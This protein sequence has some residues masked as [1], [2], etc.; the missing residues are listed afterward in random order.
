M[1]LTSRVRAFFRLGYKDQVRLAGA[2]F[3]LFL[4]RVL[5]A[6]LPFTLVRR[7]L[8]ENHAVSDPLPPVDLDPVQHARAVH[9]GRIV[10]VAAAYAPFRS[11]C[12]PQALTA[13]V[14]L[15]VCR[16]P[17]LVSFG[18]R[19][20]GDRLLAHAWVHAGGVPVTGGSGEA[21]AQVGTFTWSPGR[22]RTR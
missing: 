21:Y 16:I 19:R 3:L 1:G 9:I 13:R 8:G 18:V 5:I 17:H 20:D 22:R 2:W 11:D 12:Y 14:L 10:Q 15:A 4:S 7:L 6:V